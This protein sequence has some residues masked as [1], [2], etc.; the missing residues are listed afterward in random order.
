MSSCSAACALEH[1]S[2]SR[3][4]HTP[5]ALHAFRIHVLTRQC[6][7]ATLFAFSPIPC[8]PQLVMGYRPMGLLCRGVV[9]ETSE[10]RGRSTTP[11]GALGAR[12][13]CPPLAKLGICFEGARPGE[14]LARAE[15]NLARARRN[16]APC[17]PS[18]DE[19]SASAASVK[20]SLG[21]SM[22]QVLA[23]LAEARAL[24]LVE[25]VRSAETRL[26]A[27]MLQRLGPAPSPSPSPSYPAPAG[28]G[29]SGAASGAVF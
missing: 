2:R 18:Q 27:A 8:V 29:S 24:G 9:Q 10:P 3:L 19:E 12:A 1:R 20:R 14:Q 21:Q 26:K 13:E 4:F 17:P 7:C 15:P 5:F 22:E 6:L 11:A 28:C 23:L 16:E 25:E